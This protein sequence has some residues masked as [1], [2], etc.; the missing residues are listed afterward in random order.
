M[1][2]SMLVMYRCPSWRRHQP[3]ADSAHGLDEQWVGGI[4]LDLAPQPV[5]LNV[6]RAFA[7]GAAIAGK[8]EARHRVAR[9]GREHPHHLALA[10]GQTDDLLA[11]A[12]LAARKMKHKIAESHA[13]RR[14]RR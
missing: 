2:I 14:R 11:A 9:A 3:I 13:F 6:D 7:D 10:I 4:A 8:R 12:Q 5:D 1:P